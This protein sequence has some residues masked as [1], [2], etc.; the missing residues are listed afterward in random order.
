MHQDPQRALYLSFEFFEFPSLQICLVQFR[1][2]KQFVTFELNSFLG[3]LSKQEKYFKEFHRNFLR[4]IRNCKG[5]TS[6]AL[7]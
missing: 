5:I 4:A 1:V 6:L 7:N 2:G 3:E